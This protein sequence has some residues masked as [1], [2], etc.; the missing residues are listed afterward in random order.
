MSE[1]PLMTI[2][3]PDQLYSQQIPQ[4]AKTLPNSVWEPA[5]GHSV[6]WIIILELSNQ[7]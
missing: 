1:A 3:Y 5:A 7:N 2:I 6:S 4:A